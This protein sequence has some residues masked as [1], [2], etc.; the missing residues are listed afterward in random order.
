MRPLLTKTLV[1][2]GGGVFFA[3]TLATASIEIREG[4]SEG[5]GGS[6]QGH[7]PLA[8]Y[9][10]QDGDGFGD[11]S[12]TILALAPPAGYVGNA[13]DCDDADPTVHPSAPELCDGKDNDCDG[14]I[15]PRTDADQDGIPD[16]AEADDDADG[17]LDAA[18]NCPSIYNPIQKDTDGDGQ[19]DACDSDD[20]NDGT[21]DAQDCQS[22]DPG[23]YPGAPEVCDG[24]DNNC[25]GSVDEGFPD[26]D[27]DGR[28]DCIDVDDDSDGLPDAADNCPLNYNP[29]QKDTD[30]DGQG[31]A[32]D[33]DDDN[34]GTPDAQDCAAVNPDVHPGALEICDG[35]DN[36]CDGSVDEGFPDTDA[37]GRADCVEADDDA[38]GI[39]DAADNCPRTYNPL[40]ADVDHNGIGDACEGDTDGDGDPDY[41]DCAPR[42]PLVFD[43]APEICDG[44]DND[45]NGQVDEGF[46]DLD[47]DGV[48]N[49]VDGDDDADGWLD[50][51]DN[52]PLLYNPV[53]VDHDADGLGDEC[54]AD[55]DNDGTL[56]EADCSPFS[57]TIYPGAS[58]LC[59]GKDND[60]DG[61]VDEVACG[62]IGVGETGVENRFALHPATPNPTRAATEIT[63]E[64]PELGGA[65]RLVLYDIA[66]REVA[67]LVDGYVSGGLHAARW[68]GRQEG[69]SPAGAGLYFYRLEAP[70]F[71]EIRKL[72]LVP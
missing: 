72:V 49:C 18:D 24:L 23:S 2:L 25:D 36:D 50:L 40:Q 19:G 22:L 44:F 51:Y 31:D 64:V 11:G 37:D 29:I 13:L 3:T 66:G 7:T 55:D 43:G 68:D 54:D 41:S 69:G 33:S 6:G 52:C 1:F 28:A 32:C 62:L 58:E 70:G 21:P 20:D 12:M 60:C 56:D 57:P 48:A 14:A 63:F 46:P 71:E 16:C 34:D 17:L 59:D 38:D 67:V 45:C 4:Q 53:Q 30:G 10:D 9:R 35:L 47:G 8:W 65:V 27:A 39:L 5:G 61:M 42:D 26:A 15:E